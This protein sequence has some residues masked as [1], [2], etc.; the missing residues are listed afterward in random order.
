MRN[1]IS[2]VL[3]MVLYPLVNTIDVY[4][5]EYLLKYTYSEG[6]SIAANIITLWIWI[7]VG[8]ILYEKKK[9]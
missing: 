3:W 8:I 7:G 6:I 5:R 2:F 4:V 9:N 1:N